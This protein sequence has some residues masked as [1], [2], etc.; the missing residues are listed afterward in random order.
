MLLKT[1]Q[2]CLR[3]PNMHSPN[4]T[5][6][7][8]PPTAKELRHRLMSHGVVL[9]LGDLRFGRLGLLGTPVTV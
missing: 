6:P 1:L 5:L 8:Y 9:L 4:G 7:Q 3:R 2:T